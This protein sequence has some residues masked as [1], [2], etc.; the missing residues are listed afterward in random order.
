[1]RNQALVRA[2]RA[3][4]MTYVAVAAAV[5]VDPKTV[6][7]WVASTEC[8]PRLRARS[9]VAEFLGVP[10]G[11]LWPAAGGPMGGSRGEVVATFRCWNDL[12]SHLVVDLVAAASDRVDVVGHDERG[13]WSVR[14]LVEALARSAAGGVAVRVVLADPDGEAVAAASQL[15]GVDGEESRA[16]A[17][18]AWLQV[19]PLAAVGV[20][21]LMHD[22]PVGMSVVRADDQLMISPLLPG[23]AAPV[24]RLQGEGPL[25]AAYLA[26]CQAT[27]RRATEYR[28]GQRA[29]V[30]RRAL[31]AVQG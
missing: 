5:G 11:E 4:G 26:A 10:T 1:M 19:R 16:R 29:A 20:E 18:L 14:G 13:L 22:S 28:P 15:A 17:R 31:A 24:V 12:P 2:V 27:V 3:A 9:A 7:R 25:A 6:S 8:V 23:A 21:L 30:R